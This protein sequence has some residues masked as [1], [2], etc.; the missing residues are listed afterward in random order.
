MKLFSVLSLSL[1]ALLPFDCY[2]ITRNMVTEH[3]EKQRDRRNMPGGYFPVAD[4]ND[5]RIVTEAN[6]VL[7]ELLLSDE[8]PRSYT[9]LNALP[10]H[11]T[12]SVTVQVAKALEQVVAGLNV[13][14]ILMLTDASTQECLGAFAVSIYDKFGDLS[15]T[16]WNKETTCAHAKDSMND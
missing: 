2:G 3:D 12:N 1:L 7:S 14:M 4:V 11:S 15:I 5:P 13:R 9:F 10:G 8:P 16:K 6:F